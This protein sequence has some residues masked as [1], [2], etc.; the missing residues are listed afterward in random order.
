MSLGKGEARSLPAPDG[1]G[2][3]RPQKGPNL[4]ISGGKTG[5]C[6]HQ[7]PILRIQYET[8]RLWGRVWRVGR[9][10]N[11]VAEAGWGREDGHFVVRTTAAQ[12]DPPI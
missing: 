2:V 11:N 6:P 4:R 9:R 1:I 10:Y 5:F 3:G 8:R 7:H 12:L